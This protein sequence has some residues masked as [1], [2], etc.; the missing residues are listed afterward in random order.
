[1]SISNPQRELILYFRQGQIELLYDEPMHTLLLVCE[2]VI[3]TTDFRLTLEKALQITEKYQL[4]AWIVGVEHASVH[5]SENYFT[6]ALM[7]QM[8]KK[9]LQKLLF[10]VSPSIFGNEELHRLD[11]RLVSEGDFIA[12]FSDTEK[13]WQYLSIFFGSVA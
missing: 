7:L 12:Y 6:P 10:V 2:G 8:I 1:M 11:K 9:G 4:R 13:A 3:S 5:T